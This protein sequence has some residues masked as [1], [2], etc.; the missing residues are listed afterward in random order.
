MRK[1]AA[2]PQMRMPIF[3]GVVVSRGMVN[4]TLL[5]GV[6]MIGDKEAGLMQ[7]LFVDSA[8]FT[9]SKPP[10]NFTM[11]EG[12][13]FYKGGKIA[14]VKLSGMLPP[15]KDE[16]WDEF[17]S[18]EDKERAGLPMLG[19]EEW[20]W[21]MPSWSVGAPD[22]SWVW[23]LRRACVPRDLGR[24]YVAALRIGAP[25]LLWWD[26]TPGRKHIPPADADV[27]R[28]QISQPLDLPSEGEER[29]R[30][31]AAIMYAEWLA[32]SAD[33][34][35]TLL[36]LLRDGGELEFIDRYRALGHAF[37]LLLEQRI[38]NGTTGNAGRLSFSIKKLE[39]A[40]MRRKLLSAV[41]A[42]ARDHLTIRAGRERGSK[43]K[44]R[45]P[46]SKK[47]ARDPDE[48]EKRRKQILDVIT[49]VYRNLRKRLPAAEAETKLTVT[50]VI[51]KSGIPKSTLY[52]WFRRVGYDFED[53]KTTVL[54]RVGD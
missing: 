25:I 16:E 40:E 39:G 47:G 51:A 53:L 27:R 44:E 2:K 34:M 24:P 37:D 28:I 42:I 45:N 26:V 1:K 11:S 22:F 13:I 7:K 10:K 30:F 8:R 4:H 46:R 18:D 21:R 50:A 33:E 6:C 31:D 52:D 19:D 35:N 12:E 49:T 14:E 5:S 32:R 43:N 3:G 15:L 17:P 23:D 48:D 41:A 38:G 9:G 36:R 29:A 54:K 20:V